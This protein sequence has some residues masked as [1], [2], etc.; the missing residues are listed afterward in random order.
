MDHKTATV[1][2]AAAEHMRIR[3][4]GDHLTQSKLTMKK[5]SHKNMHSWSKEEMEF[6]TEKNMLSTSKEQMEL[7]SK[8]NMLLDSKEN[9][10]IISNK[11][12]TIKSGDSIIKLDKSGNISITGK[13]IILKGILGE[14]EIV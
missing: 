3:S 13:K 8:K 10:E 9:I 12:I 2:I 14:L 7:I 6:I 5:I 1:N 4:F 11:E